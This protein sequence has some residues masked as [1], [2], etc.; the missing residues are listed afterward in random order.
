MSGITSSVGLISGIDTAALIQSILAIE[1]RPKFLAEQRIVNLQVRQN[2]Y[3]DISARLSGLE[4]AAAAFRNSGNIFQSKLASSS[5]TATLG[6]TATNATPEGTYTFLVDRLVTTQQMLSRGFADRDTSPFGAGSITFES[7]RGRLSTDALLADLND[8]SGV[9]R[10]TIEITQGGETASINLSRAASLSEVVDAINEAQDVDITASIR[11]GALVLSSGSGDFTVATAQGS[12]GVAEDLG[13]AGTS[14]GGTLTGTA[15]SGLSN[16]TLLT[17][18]N[19]GNGV[20][21]GND[22]GIDRYDFVINVGGTNININIGAVFEEVTDDEGNTSIEEVTPAATNVQDVLERINT[23]LA[24]AGFGEVTAS[25]SGQGLQLVDSSSRELTV[26]ERTANTTTAADLG[27]LG[28]DAG[29]TLTGRRVLAGV[30]TVLLSN[31]NGGQGLSGDDQ[32]QITSRDGTLLNFDLSS[33]QTLEDVLDIVNN[34]PANAGRVRLSLNDAG[35]GL[36]LTDTT[37]ATTSNL[38]I[39]GD[40][41]SALGIATAESGVAASSQRGENLQR[42]YVSTTTRLTELNNGSS[43]GNGTFRITDGSG[44]ST[45]INIGDDT[46]TVFDLIREVNGQANSANLNLELAVNDNGDGLVFREKN[47]Q[48]AGTQAIRVE[49]ID[50]SFASALGLAGTGGDPSEPGT[51]NQ[52]V[53]SQEVTITFDPTDT[54]NDALDKINAAD[55]G[56]NAAIINDGSSV[57]PFRISFVS[58]KSGEAGRFLIDDGGFGLGLETLDEGQDARVFFGSSDPAK[59]VLLT[60]SDN[61]LD[62]VI[63]GLS[64]DL[65]ATSNDVVNVTVARNTESIEST[66][67][68][69]VSA[70][71]NVISRIE[72]LTGYNIETEQR[73]A[74]LGDSTVNNLRSRLSTTALGQALNVAGPFSRLSDVGITLGEGGLLEFDR[75]DFREALDEDPQA[76]ADVFAARDANA[77]QSEIEIEPGVFVSNSDPQETFNSLGVVFQLEELVKDYIDSV[78]GILTRRDDTVTSQIQSQ[79]DR[80]ER[81]DRQLE[82]K[83]AQ[84]EA[85]FAAMEQALLQLQS[86][87]NALTSLG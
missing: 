61:T 67:D 79:R 26:T 39:E 57:S 11:D 45:T 34:D 81:F 23:Q 2:S 17:Q 7:D 27:L 55:I 25:I 41:A 32:L 69:F 35:S 21:I 49:D 30:G 9:R 77:P 54:L 24:D 22:S 6:A 76:V 71:N 64:L 84:L 52:I 19:D 29:G 59:G 74:L 86:Q 87:Q 78:D 50:G 80:V 53:A 63:T 16:A 43:P 12:T 40:A 44:V 15:L 60:S 68:E 66:I 65:K 73:G 75:N 3:L 5:S 38:I 37:G 70:Y 58:E 36:A 31:L 72:G 82:R 33:A 1:A 85:E 8:G 20:F 13:I 42:R 18:F 10:G 14:T 46:R 56:V 4:S 83:R 48:P 28:S 51:T 47:G 62:G